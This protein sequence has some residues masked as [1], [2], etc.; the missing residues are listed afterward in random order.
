[1]EGEPRGNNNENLD[2]QPEKH[3]QKLTRLNKSI[4]D[5]MT[6]NKNIK[7]TALCVK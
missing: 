4:E 1:M 6:Q 5:A 2:S 3:R 7:K